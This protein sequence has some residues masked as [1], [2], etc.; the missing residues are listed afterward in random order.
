MAK[1]QLKIGEYVDLDIK[2]A[3]RVEGVVV[4]HRISG[5]TIVHTILDVREHFADKKDVILGDDDVVLS[6]ST[7]KD[8][9]FG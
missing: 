6:R 2:Y 3:G 5:D 1:T 7:L 8:I 4:D 9:L